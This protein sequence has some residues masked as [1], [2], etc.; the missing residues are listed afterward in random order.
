MTADVQMLD[1]DVEASLR[2][3]V[4]DFLRSQCDPADVRL[5]YDGDRSL[6]AK[7]WKV[8]ASDLGLAGLLVPE[9][10]GGAGATAREAAVVMEELGR[11]AAPVPFLE[12]G[13]IATTVLL[14]GNSDLVTDL[15]VGRRT[16]AL[17]VPFTTT[18]ATALSPIRQDSSR[19]SGRVVAVVGA[20]DADI[21]LA[22]VAAS[23]GLEIYAVGSDGVQ[24]DP[25]SSLDMTRPIADVTLDDAESQLV[26]TA[27]A[28]R[29]ALDKALLLGAAM[30]AS[31]SAGI[32][33]WSL[34]TTVKYL[35]ER[36]QFGRIVG[37][38]QAVRHRLADLYVDV[39]SSGAAAKYAAGVWAINDADIPVATAVA[40]SFCSDA[41]VHAAEEAV[42]LHGGIGMTWEHAVH[43]YLKRAK[44][45][46]IGLGPPD[47]HRD[48]LSRAIDLTIEGELSS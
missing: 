44:S 17:L 23:G 24:I 30:L 16:A 15:A 22:P 27:S 11:F 37:G 12:S 31:D 32:C 5:A 43:L 33:A 46:Q 41:A 39:E 13:V 40:A 19:L 21:F 8:L 14:A 48:V 42:Q 2:A 4:R 1:T 18:S 7:L 26:V 3:T 20:L 28:G 10:R 38:F 35:K 6:T 47:H 29:E 45:N 36:R 34:E 9:E 25:V